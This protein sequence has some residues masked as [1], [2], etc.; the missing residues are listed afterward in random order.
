MCCF[1]NTGPL[2]RR[3]FCLT[4]SLVFICIVLFEL[5]TWIPTGCAVSCTQGVR[6]TQGTHTHIITYSRET[7]LS[8]RGDVSSLPRNISLPLDCRCILRRK[9]KQKKRGSRRGIRNRLRRRGSRHPLPVMTLSNVRSLNNKLDELSLLLR[10]DE[11]FRRSNL[12]CLTETWLNDQCA[13]ELPGYTTIRADRDRRL[14]GKSIGGGLLM[15]V[16]QRWATQ[17]TVHERI[18]TKDYE[19]MVVSFRPFYLPREFGQLTVMLVGLYV[20]GPNF[21]EAADHIT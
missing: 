16:D 19:T 13:V 11:D 3:L 1:L 20:P 9:T 18:C 21:K 15:F 2:G 17:Y 6:G 4:M 5:L 12:I 10:Y 14:S 8:L 7:L